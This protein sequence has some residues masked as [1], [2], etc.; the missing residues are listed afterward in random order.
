L[1]RSTTIV[2]VRYRMEFP[3][4][5]LSRVITV[6]NLATVDYKVLWEIT[7]MYNA[8]YAAINKF[9]RDGFY[10]K[11]TIKSECIVCVKGPTGQSIVQCDACN[12]TGWIYDVF[13]IPIMS[14]I[15]WR[16]LEQRSV[17]IGA[18]TVDGDC[19]VAITQDD[20]MTIDTVNDSYLV[21]GKEMKLNKTVPSDNNAVYLLGLVYSHV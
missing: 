20:Y 4:C 13:I 15:T 18:I 5:G 1:V 3:H 11:R 8:A 14:I 6:P 16:Q 12:S 19:G 2:T 9:G 17:M 7:V 21:D 10:V